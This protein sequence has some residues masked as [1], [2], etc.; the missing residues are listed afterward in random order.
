MT[1]P[2]AEETGNVVSAGGMAD[3]RGL[4]GE[5]R[6]TCREALREEDEGRAGGDQAGEALGR[7]TEAQHEAARMAAPLPAEGTPASYQGF[8]KA[9]TLWKNS[10]VA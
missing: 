7:C 8:P 2:D 6:L 9:L 3:R 5:R 1:G 4:R 10:G